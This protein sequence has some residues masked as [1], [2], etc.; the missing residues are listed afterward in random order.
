[1]IAQILDIIV[2]ISLDVMGMYFFF[3]KH[4]FYQGAAMFAA[5]A[6]VQLSILAAK[7]LEKN[8]LI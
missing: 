3:I 6:I 4:D 5:C 1:M 7:Y 8:N 2:C